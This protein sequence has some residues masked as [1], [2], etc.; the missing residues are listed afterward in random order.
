MSSFHSSSQKKNWIFGSQEEVNSIKQKRSKRTFLTIKKASEKW[1]AGQDKLKAQGKPFSYV[2]FEN[3]QLMKKP[4]LTQS[5]EQQ[6]LNC[7][8]MTIIVI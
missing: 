1:N 8:I 4:I 5:Q 6:Y 2:P 7:L 3:N